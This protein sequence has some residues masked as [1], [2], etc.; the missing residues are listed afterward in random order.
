[1]HPVSKV[2]TTFLGQLHTAVNAYR[3]PGGFQSDLRFPPQAPPPPAPE[4]IDLVRLPLPPGIAEDFPGACNS[5]IN[6]R[7]TGCMP[8]SSGRGFQSGDFLPDGNH[9]LA[10]VQLVGA[11][12]APDPASVYN[13]SQIIIVKADGTKF[14]NGEQWKCITCGLPQENQV[15]RMEALDY[16]QAFN[17]GKRALV[18]TNVIDCGQY[19]LV[20]EECTSIHTHMY[21]LRWGTTPDGSGSGGPIRELR[22]HPDNVHLGFSAFITAGGALSELGFFGKLEFNPS[23]STGLPLS[24]RYDI[25]KVTTL[26]NPE[27]TQPIT[28]KGDKITINEQA[29]SVG[30]LRGF[31]ASG[32]EVTYIG[33][34]TESSNID[35]YAVSLSTGKIRRLTSHPEYIDPIDASPDGKW[36]AI[37]DTR[38]TGRQMFL[39]AMRSI[40]PL[41]DLVTMSVTSATRNNGQRRFFVPYL[42]DSYGDRGSYYGQKINGPGFDT[43]GSGTFNDPQWNGQADPRWSPDSTKVIYWEAQAVAPACGDPNPLPCFTS[44]EPDGKDIRMIL[45]KFISRM[46]AKFTPVSPVSDIVPWGLPYIPG[47]AEPTRP[48][49]AAGTFILTAKN[50]GLAAVILTKVA[51]TDTIKSVSVTYKNYSDNGLTFLNGWENVTITPKSATLNHVDWYSDLLQ[52]GP[53]LFA[54]KKTSSEGFHIDIDVLRNIFDANGTLTTTVNGDAY[55]QPLNGA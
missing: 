5:T 3:Y 41:T 2:I 45:A 29:I 49:P 22:L 32:S 26:L 42:I 53:D 6:S 16:P 4:P 27:I 9:V 36:W 12:P 18:G 17:D 19:L 1:M 15:G 7:K 55:L 11:P 35:V 46:P 39:A 30:E 50:T 37:M 8:I 34:P 28:T 40:P 24:P 47:A 13:G 51:G 14:A 43:I 21:P 52:T 23:P 44:N 33:Y 10:L 25:V 38:G 20:S 54:T 31:S 48:S